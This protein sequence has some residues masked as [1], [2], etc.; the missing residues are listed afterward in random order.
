[1]AIELDLK[2][3]REYIQEN[4]IMSAAGELK[5]A[6]STLSEAT[7]AGNDFLGWLTLASHPDL[8]ELQ[9]V[10]AAA[11]RIRNSADVLIVIGIGGSYLGARAV[12]EMLGSQFFNDT[13]SLK[14]YY[15]G[16][17]I[18]G[19]Y[20]NHILRNCEGKRVCVN[21]ISKSGTT[22]EPALA[23]RVFRRMLLDR[24]GADEARKRIYVTTDARRGALKTLAEREG[25]ETF[26]IP[27]DVGGR[28]SVLS[29]VGLLPIAAAG[30]DIMALLEG[31]NAA[32]QIL[33]NDSL[34]NPCNRYALT[35]NL[36]YRK[37]L[38]VEA[39]AVYEPAMSMFMEWWKQLFGESE[40]K[41]N[42]GILPVSLLF[43]T[44]LHSM[45][46]YMQEGLRIVFETV[47]RFRQPLSD[48]IIQPEEQDFD[49]LNY[50]A[51][52]TMSSIN[53]TAC[54]ATLMAHYS[55]SV[56]CI[57]I[58]TDTLDEKSA[59]ELI[60][61]FER[62]CAISAYIMD[63]NPFDQPGVEA[64]KKNMFALLGKPGYEELREQLTRQLQN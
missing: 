31:A 19:D 29:A 57:T 61:F 11:Q 46:Q 55:G 33:D 13:G 51:D 4:E 25:Y 10:K 30:F 18:S 39:L 17:N 7:G 26:V 9:R 20:L 1:M 42:K 36:L 5:S 60:Y 43:S 21:V 38:F 6:V 58:T 41:Q 56:P 64:Y 15:A 22:T 24:Y 63:I 50:L 40:G 49:G 37:G 52:D 35:R 53:K 34:D 62:A 14:V 23:F 28:Y 45:G 8:E 54:D 12:I 47:L 48:I 16:N 44:D 3:T 32:K 59:G 27:D 2:Y